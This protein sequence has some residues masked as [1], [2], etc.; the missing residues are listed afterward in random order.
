MKPKVFRDKLWPVFFIIECFFIIL[1]LL[2][3]YITFIIISSAMKQW[4]NSLE[5]I[6]ALTLFILLIPV[7][8]GGLWIFCFTSHKALDRAFG[9]LLVYEDKVIYKCFLKTPKTLNFESCKY[10]GV[11]TDNNVK[12]MAIPIIR[13]DERAHIYLSEY[14]YPAEY[15]G[16]VTFLKNKKGFIRIYYSDELCLTLIKAL[17]EEKNTLLKIFYNKMQATDRQLSN[18]TKKRKK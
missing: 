3:I 9:R 18:N 7:L 17:P 6:M 4:S 15:K 10:V 5:D 14:P 8:S 16:K 11:E 13:G 2:T 1:F 12:I